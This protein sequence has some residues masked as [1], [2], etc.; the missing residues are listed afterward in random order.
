M[1]NKNKNKKNKIIVSVIHY[2]R[3]SGPELC[4][5]KEFAYRK[6]ALKFCEKFNSKNTLKVVPDE[7]TVARI[8]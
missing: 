6:N 4:Y 8:D 5:T 7:Y 2:D 3:W 1:K